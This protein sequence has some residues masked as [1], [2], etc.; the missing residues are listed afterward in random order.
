[1]PRLG[2]PTMRASSLLAMIKQQGSGMP[3]PAQSWPC[4]AGTPDACTVPRG[5][6]MARALLQLV[7]TARL[8]CGTQ[9]T[10]V[11]CARL[12]A[13]QAVCE[14]SPGTRRDRLLLLLV[15]TILH[16]SGMLR[17]APSCFRVGT[18]VQ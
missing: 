13:T 1:M 12:P 16:V 8:G 9:A 4:S 3:S 6:P 2:V 18:L 14:T 17:G 5:V 15:M 11:C 10:E 7:W